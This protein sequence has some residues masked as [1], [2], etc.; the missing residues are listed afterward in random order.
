MLVETLPPWRKLGQTGEVKGG[1]E[2]LQGREHM[3]EEEE[4][5]TRKW[6]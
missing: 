3:E 6:P 5:E 1:E 4:E 2:A